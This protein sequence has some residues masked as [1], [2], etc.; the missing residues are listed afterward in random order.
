MGGLTEE[1]ERLRAE[2]K[3]LLEQCTRLH[4]D[5]ARLR[6]SV[7]AAGGVV[8]HPA[9]ELPKGPTEAEKKAA[10]DAGAKAAA[11]AMDAAKRAA[12]LAAGDSDDPDEDGSKDDEDGSKDSK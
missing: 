9:P 3:R 8:G 4:D 10:K 2:V 5:N 12:A 7:E 6:G 1:N 11:E